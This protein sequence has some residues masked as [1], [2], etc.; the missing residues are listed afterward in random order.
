[1]GCG[2][3]PHLSWAFGRKG[4]CIAGPGCDVSCIAAWAIQSV[5]LYGFGAVS[6][7]KRCSVE[8]MASP[9]ETVTNLR[10]CSQGS[11]VRA[12][13]SLTVHTRGLSCLIIILSRGSSSLDCS[14]DLVGCRVTLVTPMFYSRSFIDFTCRDV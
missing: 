5:F 3:R 1:M 4:V 14:S 6:D 10:G 2:R 9:R 11:H 12:R 7:G 8:M 13:A